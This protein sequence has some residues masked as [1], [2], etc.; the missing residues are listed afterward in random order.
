[1]APQR[2]HDWLAN[3]LL[4]IGFRLM[5]GHPAYFRHDEKDVEIVIHID[6]GIIE[7]L[8]ALVTE[9]KLTLQG[10]VVMKDLGGISEHGKKYLGRIIKKTAK[11]FTIHALL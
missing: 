2:F 7:E 8:S 9:I 5:V 10:K 3:L 6:D 11:D 4:S 1:M